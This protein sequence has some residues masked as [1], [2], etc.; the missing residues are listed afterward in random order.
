MFD[1]DM[2]NVNPIISEEANQECSDYLNSPQSVIGNDGRLSVG[3]NSDICKLT[4]LNL[5][6]MEN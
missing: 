1:G 2:V 6:R 5:S 4:F 3:L